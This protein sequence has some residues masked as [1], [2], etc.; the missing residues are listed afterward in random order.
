V[1]EALSWE[2]LGVSYKEGL[3]D[4]EKRLDLAC[5]GTVEVIQRSELEKLLAEKKKP[6]AYWGFECSG[7]RAPARLE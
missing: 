4:L 1:L 2:T 3:M 6:R 7:K 5:R